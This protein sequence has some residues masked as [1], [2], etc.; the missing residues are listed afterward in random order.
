MSAVAEAILARTL[1]R[2]RSLSLHHR[3]AGTTSSLYD[4]G[5]QNEALA[6]AYY[7]LDCDRADWMA[8][9][10]ECQFLRRREIEALV[11]ALQ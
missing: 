9:K 2:Q 8:V 4:A 7:D 10:N 1:S 5:A 6:I 3:I 11:E